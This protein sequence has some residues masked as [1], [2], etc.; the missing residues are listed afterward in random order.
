[1][2]IRRV[3]SLAI[4]SIIL[5]LAIAPIV[6]IVLNSFKTRVDIISYPPKLFFTPTLENFRRVLQIGTITNGLRNS[7]IVVP[8]SL[9]IG[10]VL[11]V[12]TAYI[13]ARYRFRAKSDLRF[14]VLSLRFMP[15]VAVFIPF[16]LV[17][18][19]LGL[20]DT[21]GA[22]I[23]T[24]LSITVSTMIWLSIETFKHLPIEYEEAAELDGLG[25]FGVFY[26]I[27]LPLALP[28]LLGMAVFVFILVWNEF[29]L[30]FILTA[31]NAVTMPVASATFAVMGMEV[32]WNQ[33]SAS[34]TL[35]MI[36]PLIFSYFFMKYLPNFFGVE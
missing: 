32:P 8:L 5:L 13:F 21:K 19:Q 6:W 31:R 25:P 36:P 9:L 12:P 18:L 3:L 34:V 2:K 14:F 26:K 17:W 1:M 35:L 20:L 23:A 33:L 11:G 22:L 7:L 30:A 15:P 10:F 29:F 24:Y 27:A 4:L 28:S 16:F